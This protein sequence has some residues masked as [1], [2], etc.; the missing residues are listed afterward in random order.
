MGSVLWDRFVI[1]LTD[2]AAHGVSI[3]RGDAGSPLGEHEEPSTVV[4]HQ[5]TRALVRRCGLH[6]RNGAQSVRPSAETSD[7]MLAA[8]V[9]VGLS[10]VGTKEAGAV[11]YCTHTSVTRPDASQ[12]PEVVLR[13]RPVARAPVRP[14]TLMNRGVRLIEW[15][16]ADSVPTTALTPRAKTDTSRPGDRALSHASCAHDRTVD[17]Q[18]QKVAV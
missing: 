17:I 13:P 8:L 12:G 3:P 2:A 15:S 4:T 7:I 6:L 10:G 18:P 14:R 9:I 11:V 5:Q 1:S 16:A